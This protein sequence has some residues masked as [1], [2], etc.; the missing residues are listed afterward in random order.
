MK[1][2]FVMIL[3]AAI[4][5][6]LAGCGDRGENTSEKTVVHLASLR[7]LDQMTGSFQQALAAF[8][9][10]PLDY[11]VEVVC[12]KDET[13]L[14]LAITGG[15]PIDLVDLYNLSTDVYIASGLLQDLYGYLDTDAD[16]SREELV[17]AFLE[18]ADQNGTLPF[19]S[20]SF[21]VR[22]LMAPSSLVP[23]QQGW[24]ITEFLEVAENLPDGYDLMDDKSALDFLSLYLTYT[25]E[26]Y[27]DLRSATVNLRQADLMQMM[28]YCRNDYVD[29]SQGDTPLLSYLTTV[30]GPDM[31]TSFLRESAEEYTLIGF[32]GASGN[33]ALRYY[34]AE[35]LSILTTAD[36]S[37]GAWEFLKYLLRWDRTGGIGFPVLQENF[38]RAISEAMED[39]LG[40]NG[41]ILSKGMTEAERD[42]LLAWID[43]A[44]GTGG[45]ENTSEVIS[46]LLEDAASY[47][48]GDKTMDE[49]LE[50]MENRMQIY[51]SEKRQS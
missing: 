43:N 2:L 47:I 6:G 17:P 5:L 10:E 1:R 46:I 24:T 41:T 32:P 51:L 26:D 37:D 36:Y 16:L 48:S 42:S 22:T 49:V 30:F 18:M 45:S 25:I 28:E 21:A 29:S 19:L 7:T 13:S 34:G 12:Y 11:Q 27:V 9:E 3:V 14:Q 31:Y 44:S 15:D 40:E 23:Q 20:S 39:A 50:I 35:Q 38:D 33:G 8:N 4:V